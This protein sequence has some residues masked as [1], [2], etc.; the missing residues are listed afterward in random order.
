MKA[1]RFQPC[2]LPL[3]IF[4]IRSGAMKRLKFTTREGLVMLLGLILMC[5]LLVWLIV[6]GILKLND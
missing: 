1:V 6:S 5:I 4:T 3:E 2:C